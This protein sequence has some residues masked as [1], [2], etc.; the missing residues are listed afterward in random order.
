MRHVA[1]TTGKDVE[2]RV[3]AGAIM[4][5]GFPEVDVGAEACVDVCVGVTDV[6]C[7]AADMVMS[8]GVGVCVPVGVS[9]SVAVGMA[10]VTVMETEAATA[11]RRR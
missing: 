1:E 5:A 3:T 4:V 9:V 2:V 8:V 7:D 10:V 11:M 6:T